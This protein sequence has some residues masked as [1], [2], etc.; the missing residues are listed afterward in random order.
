[1]AAWA[2]QRSR[3]SCRHF[4]II[5]TTAFSTM[6][7]SAGEGPDGEE[8]RAAM[9]SYCCQTL[10]RRMSSHAERLVLAYLDLFCAAHPEQCSLAEF[11]AFAVRDVI[12]HV[13]LSAEARIAKKTQRADQHDGDA[14]S[15]SDGE[16][17]VKEKTA[18][19]VD[20]GGG[21]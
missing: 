19:L 21:E 10:H 11:V 2:D 16:W 18:E 14:S 20:V 6:K 3:S 8:I 9:R 15:D 13:D 12:A 7:V 1:M 17:E 5:D 4:V